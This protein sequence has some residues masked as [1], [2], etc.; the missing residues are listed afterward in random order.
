[1]EEYFERSPAVTLLRELGLPLSRGRRPLDRAASTARSIR[2]GRD[3]D[4]RHLPR[5]ASSTRTS[6]PA[7]LRWNAKAW[8]LYTQLHESHYAGK[9]LPPELAELMQVEL[10]GLRRRATRLPRTRERVDPRHRW[11]PRWRSSGT[12]SPRS[13]ASTRC[14]SSSTRR[15]ASARRTTTCAGGNY[16]TSSRHS[17]R[18][19]DREPDR[20]TQR[21]RHR[22]RADGRRREAAGCS[23]GRRST[24]TSPGRMAVVTVPVHHIGR[25]QFSPPLS[26]EKWRAIRDDADGQLHQGALPRRPRGLRALDGRRRERPDAALRLPRRAASTTSSDLQPHGAASRNGS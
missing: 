4:A 10:R 2:T 24:S 6:A 8:K 17:P 20:C 13:T 14:A 19:C 25:I 12:R 5:R 22:H 23:S 15:T 11:S 3:G 18:A 21:A 26:A 7:F 9:P 16:A 1:M